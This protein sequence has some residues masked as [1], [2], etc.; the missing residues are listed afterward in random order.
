MRKWW[1]LLLL[2][3]CLAGCAEEAV[4]ERVEDD[5]VIPVMAEPKGI[6]LTLPEEAVLP[7][8]ETDSGRIYLCRD[9]DVSVQTLAGG[10]LQET[11]RSVSGYNRENLTVIETASGDLDC[12]EFVW[13]ASG[14]LGDQ[15]CRC[16]I[17]DD[18]S[19]HYVLTAT[20]DADMIGEYQEIWNGMFESF[21]LTQY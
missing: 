6:S 2:C 4:F 21:G 1:V 9:Y 16:R 3:L 14:E 17:L 20:A 12:Y 18:G 15:V 19:Y 5:V 13:T 7:A 11:I 8:M 10:D